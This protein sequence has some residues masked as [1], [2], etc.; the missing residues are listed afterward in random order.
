[1]GI[2]PTLEAWEAPVLPLNYTRLPGNLNEHPG[3]RKQTGSQKENAMN[4]NLKSLLNERRIASVVTMYPDGLPHV[5]SVW[6]LYEEGELYI[7]IASNSAKGVNLQQDSRIALSVDAR[8]CYEE[9]G[10]SVCGR[11]EIITG[12]AAEP[13]VKRLCEKYLTD[14]ALADTVVGP[15]FVGM[16]DLLVR[17]KPERWISWDMASLDQQ[18]LEGRMKASNYLKPVAT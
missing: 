7:A 2:E 5:T 4:E 9:V 14:E 1:M 11:A 8:Q 12:E 17:I 6:F 15:A 18:F 3:R 10:V 16:S 13:I